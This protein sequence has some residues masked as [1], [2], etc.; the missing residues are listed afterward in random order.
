MSLRALIDEQRAR[1]KVGPVDRAFEEAAEALAERIASDQALASIARDPY[2]PKWNT[3]WWWMLLL[4]QTGQTERIPAAGAKGMAAALNSHYLHYFPRNEKELPQGTDP[5]RQVLCHCALASMVSIYAVSGDDVDGLFPWQR[6]WFVKYQLADGG[7]NCDDSV[8]AKKDGPSS[9]MSTVPVL[10][11]FLDSTPPRWKDEQWTW[12]ERLVKYL[13]ERKLCRSLRKSGALMN[14]AFL[15]PCFPRFYDYDVLRGLSAVARWAE[16]AERPL[17]GES[18]EEAVRAIA[19]QLGDDG[20]LPVAR[21]ASR[22]EKTLWLS[23]KGK[24]ERGHPT[25]RFELLDTVS[26]VGAPSPFLTREWRDTLERLARI[27]IQ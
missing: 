2:W 1:I 7:H 4:H 9:I 24:W 20:M 14:E 21:D 6:H 22:G 11:A 17:P 23:R 26:V 3:P 13:L 10:E 15:K 25:T 8:Y 27:Q 16:I 18:I 12:S 19:N 5:W